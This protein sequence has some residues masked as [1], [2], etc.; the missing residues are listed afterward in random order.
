MTENNGKTAVVI[1]AAGSGSRYGSELPK[2]FCLLEGEPVVVHAIRRFH[3]SVPFAQIIVVVAADRKEFWE[4]LSRENNIDYTQTAIGGKTRWESVRNALEMI[5]DS[6]E[7]LLIHDGARPLVESEV[8]YRLLDAIKGGAEGALPVMPMVDSLRKLTEKGSMAVD[9]SLYQAVQTP[10]AF[11]AAL[12]KSAYRLPYSPVMTDDASVM[13]N[14]GH[15]K[16]A[17]VD[18]SEKTLK[19]TRPIDME[20]ASFYL[21]T[22]D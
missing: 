13:E 18:G 7:T 2:Q 6:T 5:D 9:R 17:L 22:S 21:R 15:M 1:V 14:A 11:S 12:L 4:N 20:A 8:I 16:M 10:Q 3:Q 19:I